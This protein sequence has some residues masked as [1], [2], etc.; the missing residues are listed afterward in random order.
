MRLTSLCKRM[1]QSGKDRKVK[2]MTKY[3]I[4]LI[5]YVSAVLARAILDYSKLDKI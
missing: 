2:K 3:F 1:G 4:I 5:F